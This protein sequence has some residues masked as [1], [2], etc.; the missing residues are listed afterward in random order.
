VVG[1]DHLVLI[2]LGYYALSLALRPRS[3]GGA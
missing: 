1:F 3:P 2:A